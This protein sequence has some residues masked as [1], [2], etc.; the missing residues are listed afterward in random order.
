V[1]G[2][3]AVVIGAG[4]VGANVAY[5]LAQAG[6][7][8]VVVDAG[9]PGGGT[10]GASF[11]WANSFGKTPRGYHDLNVASMAEHRR[12]GEELGGAW[13]RQ[14]GNL[15]WEEEPAAQARLRETAARLREW[16]YELELI[17]PAEARA[18]EPELAIGP[19]VEEVVFTPREAY[20]EVAPFV[21]ALLAAATRAGARL[22]AGRRVTALLR[23]GTRV[24]GAVLADGTRVEGDVVVN[25]AGPAA[26]EVTRMAGVALPIDGEPGRL[27]YTA[28][29]AVMLSRPIH[30]PGV[31]FRPDGAGRV[32]LAEEA[33]DLVV[34]HPAAAI[35]VGGYGSRPPDAPHCAG[36]RDGWSPERSLAAAA[37]YLPALAGTR[38]E[39]TRVG[40]RPMPRDRHPVVGGVPGLDGFYVVVSHS[41]VTLGPLWGQVAAAEIVAG[42]PD[43]RLAPFRAAR[44]V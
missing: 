2:A 27:V 7:E 21:A 6:A 4:V 42:R 16:D 34:E 30:A 37:R 41:G 43:P 11:A 19:G 32:V 13:L 8:V 20:V 3:R 33:H 24:R 9:A 39:A 22:L 12:L 44:F 5:R 15:K 10:S 40:V 17:R 25:C 14:V 36:A 38:V 18:M 35:G 29:V 31:H 26:G 23:E 1:S 28:P